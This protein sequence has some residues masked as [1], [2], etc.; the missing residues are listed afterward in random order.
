MFVSGSWSAGRPCCTEGVVSGGEE[1][2]PKLH[3]RPPAPVP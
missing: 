3:P 1:G 2:P